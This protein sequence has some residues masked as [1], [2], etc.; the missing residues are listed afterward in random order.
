MGSR[1]A[2][3]PYLPVFC[4]ESSLVYFPLKGE[5][6]SRAATRVEDGTGADFSD[7]LRWDSGAFRNLGALITQPGGEFDDAPEQK[8]DAKIS[9][10][11]LAAFRAAVR[12][13]VGAARRKTENDVL[14]RCWVA[15]V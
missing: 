2:E 1:R 4:Y 13:V 5:D 9:V 10:V 14:R 11:L 8:R 3:N 6:R 15:A 12:A 7:G